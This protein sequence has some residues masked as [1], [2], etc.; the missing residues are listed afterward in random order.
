MKWSTEAKV[1]LFTVLGLILFTACVMFLGRMEL[2][3]PPQMKIT[4]E[5]QSVTGL[6]TGNQIKYSGVTVGHVTGMQVTSKGVTLTMEINKA[7]EIPDDSEFALAN[8]GILGDKFIQITPGKSKRYLQE[9]DIIHGDG[10]SDIDKTMKQ[11]TQLM[12]EANKTLESINGII[13]DQQTQNSLKNALR[14]TEVIANNTAMLTANMNDLLA[15]NQGNLHEITNNMVDITR[16]MND[17]TAQFDSSLAQF[18]SDGQ[19]GNDMRAIVDNLKTT[20]ESINRMATSMEGVVTDPQSS[21][22]LKETLHNTAQLTTKLN[23]LTGGDVKD[24]ESGKK[25]PFKVDS[26]FEL[27]YNTTNKDIAVN[28]DVRFYS[29]RHALTLG[30]TQ[31]GDGSHLELTY[32]QELAN[33]FMLR[34]GLFDGDIGLGVDYGLGSPFTLSAAI[35]DVNDYRYRIR[36]ELRLTDDTYVIAQFIRPMDAEHGGNYFGIRQAF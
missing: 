17:I 33:R 10:Q 35:M 20:T 34:G 36:S 21:Q 1:G 31:L 26:G 22:D 15:S 5:F 30:A 27:L 13:G 25:L 19:A 9:G 4:G 28:G 32:G 18:N 11:A 29:G 12:E 2:F 6:K 24:G 3:E 14:T 16:N 23:R 7:T 8:D